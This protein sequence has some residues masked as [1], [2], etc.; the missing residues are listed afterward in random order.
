[1][2]RE[3]SFLN[4]EREYKVFFKEFKKHMKMEYMTVFWKVK[5][6]M[7]L[8]FKDI[9]MVILMRVSGKMING[10]GRASLHTLINPLTKDTF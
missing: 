10:M 9:T 8:A 7:A 5:S 4:H 3:F 2:V 1:M 6:E